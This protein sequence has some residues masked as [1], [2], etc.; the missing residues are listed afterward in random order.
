MLLA[1]H[2]YSRLCACNSVT[3]CA[4]SMCAS[5]VHHRIFCST[6]NNST[7]CQSWGGRRMVPSASGSSSWTPLYPGVGMHTRRQYPSW[8]CSRLLATGPC[9]ACL[10]LEAAQHW[11]LCNG[12]NIATKKPVSGQMGFR[13]IYSLLKK[14]SGSVYCCNLST[15]LSN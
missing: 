2:C 4:I 11:Q 1:E 12:L 14:G 3:G 9:W 7:P 5:L 6:I 8:L 13:H 10:C 15:Q